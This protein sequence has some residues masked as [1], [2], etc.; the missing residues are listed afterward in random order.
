MLSLQNPSCYVHYS[1][2]TLVCL[3]LYSLSCMHIVYC[4]CE[5]IV[6]VRDCVYVNVKIC[7]I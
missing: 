4:T 2:C 6:C 3:G 5:F 7:D 1:A